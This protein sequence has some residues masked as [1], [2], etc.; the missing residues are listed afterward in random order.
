VYVY[1]EPSLDDLATKSARM[2]CAQTSTSEHRPCMLVPRT[3]TGLVFMCVPCTPQSSSSQHGTDSTLLP[4]LTPSP[5]GSS[6]DRHAHG[7]LDCVCALSRIRGWWGDDYLNKRL[8]RPP[9]AWIS[10]RGC[11]RAAGEARAPPLG[12][13]V[14]DPQRPQ[15]C[16]SPRLPPLTRDRAGAP[17][18]CAGAT[19]GA[20]AT[21]ANP[22]HTPSMTPCTLDPHAPPP[23]PPFLP[24][25]Q[26]SPSRKPTRPRAHA[27]LRTPAHA[28]SRHLRAPRTLAAPTQPYAWCLT[29]R[30]ASPSCG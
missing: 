25:T 22:I 12:E 24:L 9:A 2:H 28:R 14:P 20:A 1:P 23:C 7:W 29:Q 5:H 11:A 17:A 15:Q 21:T 16:S 3:H 13:Y 30:R 8:P 10:A 4:Q 19:P 18:P 6:L 27:H 26:Q